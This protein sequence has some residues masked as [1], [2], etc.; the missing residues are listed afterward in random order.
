MPA[1]TGQPEPSSL[2]RVYFG[3]YRGLL[4]PLYWLMMLCYRLLPPSRK[5][6][7]PRLGLGLPR[8]EGG[9]VVWFHASSMGET[10]T[11][12][13]VVTEIAGRCKNCR[14]VV[15]TMTV[16]GQRRAREILKATETILLP[17]DF[18][19]AVRRLIAALNP[20][21]LVI[22]ET[23]IWPNLIVEAHRAGV[24]LAVVNGRISR[25]S[26]PRYK[27]IRPLTRF[28]LPR[29]DLL[30][31]RTHMDG[32]RAVKLGAREDRVFPLGNVKYD[33]LPEPLPDEARSSIRKEL[34]LTCGR[35]VIT[36]GSAR[37]GETPVVLAAIRKAAIK[38]D[39]LFIIAPRHMS[40]VPQV[41]DACRRDGLEFRT[42]GEG[43]TVSAEELDRTRVVIFAQMG[44]MLEV[45]SIS[46]IA[47]VGG[48]YKNFGG[49]NPLEPA[50]QSAVTI[51]GP[52]IQNI[53]DDI[54]YLRARKGAFL[55]RERDLPGML[56]KFAG[57]TERRK[58]IG[59]ASARAVTDRKGI[60][61]R[62]VDMMLERGFLPEE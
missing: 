54:A 7:G 57:D 24:S 20:T 26:Y 3:L 55:A 58:T 38:P 14:L 28:V 46:D 5:K 34:G 42:V 48:T 47:I 30:M 40:L 61:A 21:M 32:R 36:L 29:L 56:R 15:T 17:F 60:A 45:Y 18:H 44:R 19:P 53:R 22:G 49:H 25:K 37:D 23:E 27:M 6:L 43:E 1:D 35:L 4:M 59:E 10:S 2:G 41:E 12:A 31:M 8:M 50:S 51:V 9:P 33:N 16:A 11:I 62:C 52:H 39:P 13:P